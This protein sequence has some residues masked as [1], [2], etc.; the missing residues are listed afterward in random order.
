MPIPD[1]SQFIRPKFTVT[2]A[3]AIAE[4]IEGSDTESL[5]LQKLA[6]R[7]RFLVTSKLLRDSVVKPGLSEEEI[8]TVLSLAQSNHPE[9]SSGYEPDTQ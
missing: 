7:L 3:I 2:E 9:D 6:N 5:I 8:A 4:V 1:Q